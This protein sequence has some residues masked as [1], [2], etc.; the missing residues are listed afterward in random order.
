[1]LRMPSW[2]LLIL[3]FQRYW[4]MMSG[5]RQF[6]EH[7]VTVVSFWYATWTCNLWPWANHLTLIV[8]SFSRWQVKPWSWVFVYARASK[9]I[10]QDV[11][12]IMDNLLWTLLKWNYLYYAYG[13][14]TG[15]VVHD[16]SCS[17]WRVPAVTSKCMIPSMDAVE[18]H[19]IFN[20]RFCCFF[21]CKIS[22]CWFLSAPEILGYTG[23]P[24]GPEVDMW[25]VGVILYIL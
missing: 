17:T 6:V 7:L 8:M 24:Y 22:S 13:A 1:M 12:Y 5:C 10:H 23:V 9:R 3:V 15:H 19:C 14:G 2:K 18:V 11:P 25:S 4:S 21:L 16:R 20:W